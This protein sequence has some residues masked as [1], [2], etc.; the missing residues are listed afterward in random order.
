MEFGCLQMNCGLYQDEVNL[1]NNG[2]VKG[3]QERLQ[4]V[5]SPTK[6]VKKKKKKKKKAM[7]WGCRERERERGS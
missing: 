7:F 3:L 4:F 1:I 5:Y 6:E 2:F